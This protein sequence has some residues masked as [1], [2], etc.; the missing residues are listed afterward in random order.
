MNSFK[1]KYILKLN[2]TSHDILTG[3]K[4]KSYISREKLEVEGL[5]SAVLNLVR[6]C[7]DILNNPG[8]CCSNFISI[9]KILQNHNEGTLIYGSEVYNNIHNLY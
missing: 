4:N 6:P 3:D 1:F 5:N 8:C 7:V 2:L 9:S